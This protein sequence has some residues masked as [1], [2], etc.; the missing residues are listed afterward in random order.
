M[1]GLS[2][3][4]AET[5]SHWFSLWLYQV[6]FLPAMARLSP[7]YHQHLLT[8]IFLMVAD[9]TA[10]WW[11]QLRVMLSGI[12]LMTKN[13]KRFFSSNVYFPLLFPFPPSLPQGVMWPRLASN[14]LYIAENDFEAQ[15]FVH[16]RQASYQLSYISL[17]SLALLLTEWFE[18]L[19]CLI[20]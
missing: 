19:G 13:V 10:V 12:S 1:T 3:S 2:L 20:F 5:F 7:C 8:F 15:G 9:L 17:N 16:T 11:E 6:I 14:P 4:L 18:G